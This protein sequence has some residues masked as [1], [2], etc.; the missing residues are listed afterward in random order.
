MQVTMQVRALE[1]GFLER[2]IPYK[3]VTDKSERAD[4][5]ASVTLKNKLFIHEKCEK[6]A[7]L[8][9]KKMVRTGTVTPEVTPEVLRML[10]LI[11]NEMTR[12]EIQKKL[13]LD[14][15]KHFREKYQQVGIKFG[16]IEM[17]MPD[18]PNSRLQ[19]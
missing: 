10:S 9:S 7:S 1:S 18:H 6:P 5:T 4:I 14:N 19:K 17:T 15:E 3:P 16:L 12:G 2:A 13:G 11:K 8:A